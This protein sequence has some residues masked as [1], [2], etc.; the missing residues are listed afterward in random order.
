MMDDVVL[1]SVV[2]DLV[3]KFGSLLNVG[4]FSGL[5]SKVLGERYREGLDA[6]E[7]RFDMNFSEN[8]LKLGFLEK[9]TFENIRGMNEEI[10]DK[11]RKELSVGLLNNESVSRLKERVMNVMGVMEDRARMIARTEA[12]RA[13]NAGHLDGARQSGLDVWKRWD[14]H[15]D[16]RTSPVCRALNGRTVPLDEKFKFGGEEFDHPPAHPNCRSTLVFV[17]K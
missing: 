8:P 5:I 11:L 4:L 1:K 16:K 10:A 9:Y 15:L 17:Q 12:N 2:S 14:A 13:L 6:A 7:L 3:N